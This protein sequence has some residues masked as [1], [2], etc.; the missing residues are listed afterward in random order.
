MN[1]VYS[2]SLN[3]LPPVDDLK[4]DS[5]ALATEH[6]SNANQSESREILLN[7]TK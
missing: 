4:T 1:L 5:R 2:C 3:Y 7:P 6:E